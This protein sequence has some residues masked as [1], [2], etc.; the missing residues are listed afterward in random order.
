MN[1]VR[2]YMSILLFIISVPVF[3]QNFVFNGNIGNFRS[4]KS[5]S[6]NDAGFIFVIDS[7]NSEIIKLDTLGNIIKRIGGF[8]WQESSFDDPED[9]FANT[10]YFYVADKNNNRIQIFDKDMNFL[11]SLK[12]NNNSEHSFQ[13]PTSLAVSTQGD[14]YILDSDNSRILKY[15]LRGE[16]QFQIGGYDAG[17]FSLQSPKKISITS[18]QMILVVDQNNLIVFDSFGNG[19]SKTKLRFLLRMR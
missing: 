6:I 7:N 16:F 9:I 13:Y 18:N 14:F 5:F 3:S 2:N 19:L 17:S 12:T 4:A 8:G 15:N 1:L 10:L 11:S